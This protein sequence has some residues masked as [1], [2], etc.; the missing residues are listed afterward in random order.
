MELE[1]SLL[2]GVASRCRQDRQVIR[3]GPRCPPKAKVTR[4]NRV[5]VGIGSRD[6]L[7]ALRLLLPLVCCGLKTIGSPALSHRARFDQAA[8]TVLRNLPTSS[9]SRLESRDKD[10]A[11]EST[12]EDADPVSVEPRCTSVMLEETCWV[13]CAAC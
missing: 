11:A 2:F 6:S 5:G 7:R 9:L 1:S 4:S 13:P 12:C 8:R 10:C 3:C